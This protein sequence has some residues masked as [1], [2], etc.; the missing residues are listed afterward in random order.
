M[1]KIREIITIALTM[2]L[3]CIFLITI[4]KDNL[5]YLLVLFISICLFTFIY[6]KEN[7]KTII[8]SVIC[9]IATVVYFNFY[10]GYI[11]ANIDKLSNENTKITGYITQE[12]R[13]NF[14][15]TKYTL[16]IEE[17][18]NERIYQSFVQFYSYDDFNI[19]QRLSLTGNI[20]VDNKNSYTHY[21]LSENIIGTFYPEEIQDENKEKTSILILGQ[22]MR[23]DIIYNAQKL[24]SKD[25]LGISLAMGYSDKSYLDTEITDAFKVSGVSHILVVSGLHVAFIALL[26]N[27]L[28]KF[29]PINKKIKNILVSLLLLALCTTIGFTYSII[30][31]V[32]VMVI[33]LIAKNFYIYTDTFSVLALIIIV[34]LILNPY[35]ATSLSL[36]LSY[37]ACVGVICSQKIIQKYKVNKIIQGVVVCVFATI[38]TLP[39]LAFSGIEISLISPLVN[40]IITI[41]AMP[42]CVLSF[43]TVLIE[44]LPIISIINPIL[45]AINKFF[46]SIIL[47]ITS[48]IANNF[49]FALIN[50]SDDIFKVAIF[51]GLVLLV[52]VFLNFKFNKKINIII[53]TITFIFTTFFGIMNKDNVKVT[54]M[55]TGS[56][57]SSVV[58]YDY[59]T[60]LILHEKVS[61]NELVYIL[62]NYNSTKFN[63]IIICFSD[64]LDFSVENYGDN[65][66]Y[67]TDKKEYNFSHYSYTILDDEVYELVCGDLSVVTSKDVQI[68]KVDEDSIYFT[69]SKAP[70]TFNIDTIYYYL[71]GNY[72]DRYKQFVDISKGVRLYD[73]LEIKVNT[74]TKEYKIIKDVINF[75]NRI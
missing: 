49:S 53:L 23:E 25:F 33:L 74:K 18:E 37:S 47:V 50:L 70:L 57:I 67:Q 9:M 51:I 4:P 15:S 65:I 40:P 7:R 43:L 2:L 73:D 66:Y 12:E 32:F 69:S 42:V 68:L 26:I 24:Y 1:N 72:S 46:I 62:R 8:I 54:I 20:N 36:L 34:T 71:N 19:G 5:V 14:Y 27:Y 56:F 28:F 31:A 21:L 75:A 30:R 63:N 52:I 11:N 13:T 17:I 59:K 35:S 55:D 41:L 6:K 61:E 39:I 10:T 29:L 45:V 48:F 16:K 64:D 3:T 22:K 60:D 38:F 58:N 44:F